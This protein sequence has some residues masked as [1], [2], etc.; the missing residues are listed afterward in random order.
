MTPANLAAS[1]VNWTQD[2]R[3]VAYVD[4]TLSNV[5]GLVVLRKNKIRGRSGGHTVR[6]SRYSMQ[7]A[8]NRRRQDAMSCGS[9]CPHGSDLRASGD[10]SGRPGRPTIG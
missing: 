5:W 9:W 6:S 1:G 4:T 10:G 3:A 2:S 7:P 8:E